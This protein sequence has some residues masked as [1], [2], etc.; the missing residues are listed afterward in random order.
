[1]VIVPR[2][3]IT[4]GTT[5][6]NFFNSLVRFSYSIVVV[7]FVT[8]Q[9]VLND[10]LT[11]GGFFTLVLIGHLSLEFEW[12]KSLFESPGFFFVL[13][14]MWRTLFTVKRRF[15]HWSPIY[16]PFFQRFGKPFQLHHIQLLLRSHLCFTGSFFSSRTRPKYFF[17]I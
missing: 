9:A 5:V 12:K 8:V 11:F 7:V 4:I 10:Y 14:P 16:S 6:L 3:Q 13:E 17:I 1:M 2:A 15:F